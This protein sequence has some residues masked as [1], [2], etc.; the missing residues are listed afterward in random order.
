MFQFAVFKLLLGKMFSCITSRVFYIPTT[1]FPPH[2]FKQTSLD[3]TLVAGYARCERQTYIMS[4]ILT[5]LPPRGSFHLLGSQW[6][7]EHA[8]N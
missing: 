6:T 4:D 7:D 8:G 3:F 5:D 1:L 2:N